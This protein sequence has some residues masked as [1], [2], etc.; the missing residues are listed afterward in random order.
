M[1]NID[2]SVLI[3][4]IIVWIL[5]GF[6]KKIFFTPVGNIIAEREKKNLHDHNRFKQLETEVDKKTQSLE[7]ELYKSQLE[8]TKIREEMI[9]EGNKNKE[10]LIVK[11]TNEAKALIKKKIDKFKTEIG[12]AEKKLL[13]EIKS[14]SEI[15]KEKFL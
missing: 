1:L 12:E 11:T 4:I 10:E 2:A 7:N 9:E 6:L 13:H 15:I 5:L 8:C 3:V 14:F